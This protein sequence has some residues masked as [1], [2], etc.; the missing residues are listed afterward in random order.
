MKA[1]DC[2][3]TD[4]NVHCHDILDVCVHSLYY[5]NTYAHICMRAHVVHVANVT[6][7]PTLRLVAAAVLRSSHSGSICGSTAFA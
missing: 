1:Y 5:C 6:H 2:D 4:N 7:G 3:T